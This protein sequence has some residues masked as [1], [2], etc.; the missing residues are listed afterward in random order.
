MN[1]IYV[2]KIVN[3]HGIKGEI[4]IISDFEKKDLVFRDGFKIYI[5]PNY[6]EEIVNT[7]RMHKNYDM[8]TLK[9]INDINSVLKYKGEKVYINKEDLNLR[10]SDYLINDL[11]GFQIICNNNNY[12]QVTSIE[13]SKAHI[14][15]KVCKNNKEYYIP[16][17][18]EFITNVNLNNQEI[19][20]KRADE[21]YEIWYFNSFS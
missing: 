9:G 2:G 12:G 7:Y 19:E 18:K 3:T 15:L 11:I 4:R 1:N 8:I 16:Y 5:G 17:L 21:F 14:L 10:G 13:K 6:H 20:V